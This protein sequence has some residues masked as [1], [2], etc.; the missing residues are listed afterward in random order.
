MKNR[1]D[2]L[3]LTATGVASAA[4]IPGDMLI[5]ANK[6]GEGEKIKDTFSLGM[7]GYSF[8]NLSFEQ[9]LVIMK[10][11]NVLNMSLK[12]NYLPLS[13]EKVKI[14]EVTGR[15]RAAGINIY[16]VGVITMEKEEDVDRAFAYASAAGVKM[17]VGQPAPA[18]V[19]YVE[20]KVKQYD[21]RIAM[22]N[23]GPDTKN[24]PTADIIWD[25]IKS[26]DRR[27][28]I[29]LDIGHTTRAGR[30]AVADL[31]K[32]APRIYDIHIKDVTGST[33]EGRTIEMGRGVIDIPAFVKALRK[34]KYS[35]MCS[36]EFEKD[37]DDPLGGIAES[38]GYLR[39][40]C[41]SLR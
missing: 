23:H 9:A 27:M 39:G 11:I 19:S 30:D 16:T 3:R 33:K 40:V 4:L 35:G 21:I 1:R 38:I 26:L 7:A 18:L 36:L 14:E 15:F 37:M 17:I 41:A 25:R 31:I 28:G 34:V 10:R 6:P 2:F 22:H 32:Y 12:D 13:S 5:R 8:Y 29:C 20:E 24:F